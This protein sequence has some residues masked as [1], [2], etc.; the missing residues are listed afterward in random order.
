MRLKRTSFL[1]ACKLR[2]SHNAAGEG[3]GM[4]IGLKAA[5]VKVR[6]VS[7]TARVTGTRPS[8][9]GHSRDV[10]QPDVKV[11]SGFR[12]NE[13]NE[14][15]GLNLLR[16][17]EADSFPLCIFD[18]QYRGVLDR[19][20]YGNEGVSRQQERVAL[21]QMEERQIISFIKEISRALMPSGH[22]L[23]WVDK[24]HLCQG[25]SDWTNP[26]ELSIVDLIVWYKKRIGMGYRTRRT[27]EYCI[28][29]QK[30][31]LRAK[32]VWRSHDIPDVWEEEKT[33]RT[34][35][36]AKPIALQIKLIETL[37]NTKDIV[38]DPAAGS[39]SV[40]EAC[41]RTNR[42]FLGCDIRG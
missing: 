11:P 28:V 42:R 22:L 1:Y 27:S 21:P 39:F 4:S 19:Q 29:L 13:R 38:I 2:D 16:S 37:T 12:L 30:R 23:L 9:F 33:D 18:P 41:K 3:L 15:D 35:T 20:K 7:S 34:F 6:A 5:A 8:V 36:H 31:P 17:L 10:E 32:G 26:T 14:A 24:Y 25:I 40:L